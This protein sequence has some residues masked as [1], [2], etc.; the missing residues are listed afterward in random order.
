[1]AF[2]EEYWYVSKSFYDEMRT[3]IGEM[4]VFMYLFGGELVAFKMQK[5][6]RLMA[7]WLRLPYFLWR[8]GCVYGVRKNFVEI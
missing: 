1:M 3:F 5:W 2:Y 6:L 8:I 7:K 4:V